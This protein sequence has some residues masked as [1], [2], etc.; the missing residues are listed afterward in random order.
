MNDI[1]GIF[2]IICLV[3]GYLIPLFFTVVAY[4][5]HPWVPQLSHFVPLNY[6][7]VSFM[8]SYKTRSTRDRVSY[9]V[10]NTQFATMSFDESSIS[11]LKVLLPLEIMQNVGLLLLLILGKV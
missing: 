2:Y 5:F 1:I 9:L 7:C 3:P 4:Y 8:K 10:R 6:K 11:Q